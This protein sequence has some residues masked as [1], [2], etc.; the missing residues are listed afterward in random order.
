MPKTRLGR[1]V[2]EGKVTSLTEIFQQGWNPREVEIVDFLLP[3]LKDEV[4]DINLVQR[5]TDAGEKSRFRALVVI[6]NEEGFV[7]LG[8]GKAPRVREAI[9]KGIVD[10]KLNIFPVRRGCG[11]WECACGDPHSLPF[12]VIGRCGSV[13]VHLVPG[14]RGVGLVAGETARVVLR[15]AGIK[16]CWS[17]SFGSTKTVVSFAY[18]TFD[19][20]KNTERIMTPRDWAR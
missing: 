12:K 2:L 14:P 3:N 10:A 11:S 7:G 4:I 13:E 16:D 5:Q 15:L 18:A 20:L 8:M 19:A 6:G 9:E 1:M 17:K